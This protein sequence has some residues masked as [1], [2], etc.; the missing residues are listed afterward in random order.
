M[1]TMAD[2]PGTATSGGVAVCLAEVVQA[3]V[4]GDL[5]VRL[6]ARDGSEARP[7]G[8]AARGAAQP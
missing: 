5:P 3:F 4:G 7:R 2:R 6:R 8:G 1:T